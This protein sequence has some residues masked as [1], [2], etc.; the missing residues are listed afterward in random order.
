MATTV[1]RS[2]ADCTQRVADP[3]DEIAQLAA[4]EE[5]YR[6][7]VSPEDPDGTLACAY[8]A[9]RLRRIRTALTR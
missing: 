5:H 3:A 6:S 1:N 2:I 8:E 9:R 4:T 7:L